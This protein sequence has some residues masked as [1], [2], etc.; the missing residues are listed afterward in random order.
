VSIL[1]LRAYLP[2]LAVG[3]GVVIMSGLAGPS[4][5]A[6]RAARPA[7]APPPLQ[8]GAA[9]VE[10]ALPPG[11]P[12]A[13]GGVGRR[14]LVPDILQRYPLVFWL[15]PSREVHVPARARALLLEQ[16]A[17]R[18]LW[19]AVDLV[20]IDPQLIDDL[21][22]RLASVGLDYTAIALAASHT[23]SGPGGFARSPLFEFLTLDRYVPQIAERLV[24]DMAR[25]ARQA[26]L[27]KAPARVGGGSRVVAGIGR[28][29][30]GLDLDEE[31]GVL[32]IFKQ[33][34]SPVALVWNFAVH[35]TTLRNDPV[36]L[37][38]DLMGVASQR[39]ER[40]LGVPVLY[41]NG[42]VA[43]VSPARH[44]LEG[45]ESLGEELA[46]AVQ[47][48]WTR[49]GPEPESALQVRIEPIELP[50]PRLVLR[51]C[52]ARWVPPSIT[53]DLAWA[54]PERAEL[55]GIVIGGHA[56]VTMPG[57][58]QTR[59][60]QEIKE[61]GR[62]KFRSTSVVF[63]NNYLGYFMT[64][65]ASVQVGPIQCGSLYGET[66]GDRLVAGAKALLRKLTL[67]S[68]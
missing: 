30:L 64:P 47:E 16:G 62:G 32:K 26:E 52:L 60:G 63:A 50:R 25:A 21:R 5:G 43:D 59:L 22:A 24:E 12:L 35:G 68:R 36:R 41:T 58:L 27:R 6:P 45:A 20:A 49:V 1:E 34:G 55:L 10:I 31:L 4:L 14:L 65:E 8:A 11:V 56:V 15:K 48:V 42:A 17:T 57:E 29:R 23:H 18:L 40:S 39:L 13:G 38:G 3:V 7:S 51:S 2:T 37:S 53:L 44:R 33:D 19:I 28:S 54:L 67:P 46:R 66:A 61:A 9:T